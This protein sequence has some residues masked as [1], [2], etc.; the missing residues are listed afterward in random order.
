MGARDDLR[1]ELRGVLEI[2]VHHDNGVAP[3]KIEPGCQSNLVT[4]V[5]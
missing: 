4:E 5:A 3:R 1:D 2:G